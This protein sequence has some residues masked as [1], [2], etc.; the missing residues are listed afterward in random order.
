[1]YNTLGNIFDRYCIEREREGESEVLKSRVTRLERDGRTV[2]PV[3]SREQP[4]ASLG[5]SGQLPITYKS[6][7]YIQ[8]ALLPVRMSY[9][10]PFHVL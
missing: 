1:M 2:G 6:L 3:W 9:C 4:S 7:S 10:P 5:N 8:R